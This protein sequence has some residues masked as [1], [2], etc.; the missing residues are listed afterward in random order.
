MFDFED[1]INNTLRFYKYQTKDIDP[2]YGIHID[3]ATETIQIFKPDGTTEEKKL[4]KF[5]KGENSQEATDQE[6]LMVMKSLVRASGGSKVIE[7]E[8][9]LGTLEIEIETGNWKAIKLKKPGQ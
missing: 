6:I 4:L 7:Y 5:S 2:S 8:S 1:L 3:I 9:L